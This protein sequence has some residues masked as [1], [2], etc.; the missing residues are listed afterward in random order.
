MDYKPERRKWVHGNITAYAL[1][2]RLYTLA[3]VASSCSIPR[4]VAVHGCRQVSC[5]GRACVAGC[6]SLFRIQ[7]HDNV[8][9]LAPGV[10]L[11][12][13]SRNFEGFHAS[14]PGVRERRSR[15]TSCLGIHMNLSCSPPQQVSLPLSFWSSRRVS[16]I[17]QRIDSSG[18][19]KTL[20]SQCLL[21]PPTS[22]LEEQVLCQALKD[23]VLPQ[24]RVPV[25]LNGDLR[26]G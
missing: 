19:S 13:R 9:A 24:S 5:P 26:F 23:R 10:E 20:W 3:K 17:R 16:S 14:S 2:A 15:A 6:C 18:V 4:P 12:E 21:P 7:E 1:R 11:N 22:P 25:R 8:G